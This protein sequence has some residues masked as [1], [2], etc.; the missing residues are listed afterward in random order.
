MAG[1]SRMAEFF[2]GMAL[3]F[4]LGALYAL[5]VVWWWDRRIIEI[6]DSSTGWN[7]LQHELLYGTPDTPKRI[8]TIR[9]ADR[10]YLRSAEKYKGALR[11]LAGRSMS[12][13]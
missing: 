1:K 5:G 11:E 13:P 12:R 8:E 2:L 4:S 3:T 9:R 7:E 10:I 6:Y